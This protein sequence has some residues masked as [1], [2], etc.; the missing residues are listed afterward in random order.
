MADQTLRSSNQRLSLVKYVNET[1]GTSNGAGYKIVTSPQQEDFDRLKSIYGGWVTFEMGMG[2]LKP[3][4]GIAT[5][6]TCCARAND[7]ESQL[8]N[9]KDAMRDAFAPGTIV[10]LYNIESQL[11]IGGFMVKDCMEGP[12]VP[13]VGGGCNVTFT[14]L[15]KVGVVI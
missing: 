12:A 1:I 7:S 4:M 6:I 9:M 13:V 8:D 2:D 10:P 15:L 3:K 11:R 14:V 5:L